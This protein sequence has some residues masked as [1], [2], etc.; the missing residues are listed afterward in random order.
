MSF[1]A[2]TYT[3][4]GPNFFLRLFFGSGFRMLDQVRNT[5]I[6]ACEFFWVEILYFFSI[7]PDYTSQPP[8][9]VLGFCSL[10]S[11]KFH[12]MSQAGRLEGTNSTSDHILPVQPLVQPPRSLPIPALI[13]LLLVFVSNDVTLEIEGHFK[14]RRGQARTF[15]AFLVW[16]G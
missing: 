13:F 9:C 2:R 11:T 16:T 8:T 1:G 14:A 3:D 6:D 10:Y 5:K 7:F 15:S 12:I 4:R